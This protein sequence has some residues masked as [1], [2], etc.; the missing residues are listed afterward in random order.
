MI[1]AV[2]VETIERAMVQLRRA[3]SRRTL[4]RRSD[5]RASVES[6]ALFAVL[7]ALDDHD[8]MGVT[9][10]ADSIAVDQPRAS[11]LVARAV[12]EGLVRRAADQA[13]GR[14][15]SLHLTTQG[16]RIVDTAHRSRRNAI[17]D[18]MAAFSDT[19]GEEFARLLSRF[20][21]HW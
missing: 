2:T 6:A 5:R 18:A 9:Q 1:D 3:M 11:K 19:E 4:Q 20:V 12:G 7:D 15:Q 8:S 13:D 17:A 16:R 10:I 14:R 21:E